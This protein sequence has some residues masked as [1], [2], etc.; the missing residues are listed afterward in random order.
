MKKWHAV[1]MLLV[2]ATLLGATVLREPIAS[3]AQSVS[4]TIIGP[5]DAQGN[6]KVH[7]QAYTETG[8][9]TGVNLAVGAKNP[10]SMRGTAGFTVDR[11]FPIFYDS[12]VEAEFRGQF[13]REFSNDPYAVATSFAGA[14]PAFVNFSNQRGANLTFVDGVA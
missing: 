1:A 12:Y 7:E 3:A 11:N 2:G 8:A 4:A 14:G 10:D 6:V 13:T 9:G 5:L